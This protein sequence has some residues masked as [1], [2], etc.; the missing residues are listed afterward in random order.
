MSISYADFPYPLV[1]QPLYKPKIWGGRQL[2]DILG[3]E[4]PDDPRIGEAW[5]VSDMPEGASAVANGPLAGQ[6]LRDVLA[7]WGREILGV[8]GAETLADQGHPS[9]IGFPILVKFIDAQEDLSIQ[10][11]PSRD[12]CRSQFP[13]E[14]SKDET[15]IVI[16]AE[17]GGRVFHGFNPGVDAAELQQ[18]L[19]DDSVLAALRS[20][21]VQAG[22]I[23]Q[24]QSGTVHAMCRGLVILEIQDPSVSTFRLYD[25]GRLGDNGHPR[26]LHIHQAQQVLRYDMEKPLLHPNRRKYSWGWHETV[27][28]CASYRI[29]RFEARGL[30]AWSVNPRTYQ[31]LI[32][33]AGAGTLTGGSETVDLIPGRTLLLPAHLG[34]VRI[35]SREGAQ[36]ILAGAPGP[37]LMDAA[38]TPGVSAGNSSQ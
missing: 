24:I 29:E 20:V 2:A 37:M 5:E 16:H 38:V 23:I 12:D 35:A 36:F 10:V 8:D 17:P 25:Y 31:V 30:L 21:E 27:I 22:D 7:Q 33:I 6:S 3:K 26:E 15:W 18:R 19:D 13:T 14:R 28:D 34:N 1:C 32:P 9:E 11:H 4:L